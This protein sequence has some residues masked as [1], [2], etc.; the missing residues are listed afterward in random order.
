[1]KATKTQITEAFSLYWESR[2][3][4]LRLEKQAAALKAT[5]R[6]AAELLA[7]A[8]PQNETLH[9][10]HRKTYDKPTVLYKDYSAYLLSLL[11]KTKQAQ[12]SEALPEYT[13]TT[14]VDSF[15]AS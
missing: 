11:P 10:V 1:M 13:K 15:K 5:E 12:A 2:T 9:G 4:R 7:Q 6:E 3:E 14:I 8:I